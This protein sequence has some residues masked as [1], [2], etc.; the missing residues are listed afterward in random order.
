MP[1]FYVFLYISVGKLSIYSCCGTGN[2]NIFCSPDLDLFGFDI[3][4]TL[5][6][7]LTVNI[8]TLFVKLVF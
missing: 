3:L 7:P 2:R 4:N 6:I 5:L 8:D 1:I